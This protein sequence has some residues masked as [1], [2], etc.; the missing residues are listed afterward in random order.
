M[1]KLEVGKYYKTRDGSKVGPIDH[2]GRTTCG[3]DAMRSGSY[4]WETET[5]K[6][7]PNTYGVS[8]IPQMDIIAEWGDEHASPVR[9]VTRKEIVPGVYGK[10][11]I[12][13]YQ[14]DAVE[15]S[16]DGF[17]TTSELRSAIATLTEIADAMDEQ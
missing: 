17:L 9:T 5:G 1:V 11:G 6:N 4:I 3:Y 12:G 7:Y 2:Y 10:V 13:S 15:V 14:V 16:I 8:D